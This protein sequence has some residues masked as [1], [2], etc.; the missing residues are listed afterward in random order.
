MSAQITVSLHV[1]PEFFI[2]SNLQILL[3]FALPTVVVAQL[4]R[5]LDCGSRGRGFEPHHPPIFSFYIVYLK[6][7]GQ[8]VFFRKNYPLFL[9]RSLLD[10]I[11]KNSGQNAANQLLLT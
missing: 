7:S 6:D 8:G 1:T 3:S 9:F 2:F 5:A 10:G 11:W 4:V